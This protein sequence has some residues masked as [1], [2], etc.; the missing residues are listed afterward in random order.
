MQLPTSAHYKPD[1]IMQQEIINLKNHAVTAYNRGQ[2]TQAKA[3]FE[4]LLRQTPGDPDIWNMLGVIYGRM[5]DT[6]KA[7][8][9]LRRT[10]AQFPKFGPARGNLGLLLS[11]MGKLDEA[12]E[13]FRKAITVDPKDFNAHS[14]LGTVLRE[15]GKI[16]E[17]KTSFQSA[18]RLN[19]RFAQ[20]HNNLG[21]LLHEQCRTEEAISSFRKALKH[22][23]RYAQAHFNLGVSL[24]SDGAHEQAFYHYQKAL[25][26]APGMLEAVAAIAQLRE[27][28]GHYDEA[29]KQLKPYIEAGR[30]TPA[31]AIAFGILSRRTNMQ[32]DGIRLLEQLLATHAI[33]PLQRQEIEFLLGDLYNDQEE[34]DTAFQHY[35]SGNKTRPQQFDSTANQRYIDAIV[36][37]FDRPFSEPAIEAGKP[38]PIF[39]VGMPRSGTTLIEQ[40]LASHPD[41]YGAGELSWIGDLTRD[42]ESTTGHKYPYLMAQISQQKLHEFGQKYHRKLKQLEPSAAFICDKMPH[43]F[44]FVGLI[45]AAIPAARIVHVMRNPLDVCLSI[46]FHNFNTNHPYSTDLFSLGQYYRQYEQLMQHWRKLYGENLHEIQYENLITDQET[47]SRRLLDYCGLRW[48]ENCLEFHTSRRIVNTPSY[49][50]VRQPVY[51]SSLDRWKNYDKHLA[52]LKAGLGIVQ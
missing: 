17:A 6:A 2:L 49:D 38:T 51:K 11:Q 18:I 31:I 7:E 1:Q 21:T 45:R 44:L 3:A 37:Y 24:Q 43:N 30:V 42:L 46:Y 22:E 41:V 27:K 50:Q 39:I 33:P 36:E 5:G 16:S 32:S 26:I 20:A 25:Q 10:I 52:P 48:N 34:Y 29:V 13:C 19:P 8:Q 9:Y 40:I 23:P 35:H 4:T 12:E 47:V 15:Q 28:E 14:N